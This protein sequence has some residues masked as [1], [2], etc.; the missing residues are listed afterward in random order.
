M[1]SNLDRDTPTELE[2]RRLWRRGW[3]F[4]LLLLLIVALVLFWK[5]SPE[6]LRGHQRFTQLRAFELSERR[7]REVA[8]SLAR[9]VVNEWNRFR[10]QNN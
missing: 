3:L 10:K 1:S 6:A 2:K 5:T 9:D 8:G 7:A 4:V